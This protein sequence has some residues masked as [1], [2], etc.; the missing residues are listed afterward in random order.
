MVVIILIAAGVTVPMLSGSSDA[1]QMRDAVR[2]TVRLSRYARSMAIL[3]QTDC[4]LTFATN[5]ITLTGAN[6]ALAERRLSDKISIEDFENL[7]EEDERREADE[8]D[9][10]SVLFYSSGMN[11]GFEMTF[12]DEDGRTRDIKCNPVT[13]KI[14]VD[15]D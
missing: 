3:N 8:E 12:S 2:S 14:T 6:G 10:K 13:G 5:R 4:T 9:G 11:D 1:A 15:E 7:A